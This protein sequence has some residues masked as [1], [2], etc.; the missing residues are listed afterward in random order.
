M[1]GD[2]HAGHTVTVEVDLAYP[3][4][5]EDGQ[6]GTLLVATEDGMDVG[7]TGTAPVAGVWV[8]GHGEE[9]D[10]G[11]EGTVLTDLFV[12]V[13]ADRDVH[14][15]GAGLD[16]VEAELIPVTLVHWLGSGAQIVEHSV[17]GL[18]VPALA[19]L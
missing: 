17:E 3:C 18:E 13:V 2:V 11:L 19:T 5:G 15:C 1:Q 12:K 6:V 14:L 8:V 16:P 4:V 10:A 7:Y 9:T